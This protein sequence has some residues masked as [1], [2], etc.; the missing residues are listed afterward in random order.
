[1]PV[2][3]SVVGNHLSDKFVDDGTTQGSEH[4]S[5]I[6][7]VMA[8][9]VVNNVPLSLQPKSALGDQLLDDDS[10]P[11]RHYHRHEDSCTE[12]QQGDEIEA[13]PSLNVPLQEEDG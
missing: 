4:P 3:N 6:A 2:D 5:Y 13:R 12:S 1:M 7:K 9:T 11:V 8:S 10:A